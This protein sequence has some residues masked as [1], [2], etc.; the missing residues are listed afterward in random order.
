[1]GASAALALTGRRAPL[2]A[3]RGSVEQARDGGP[4]LLTWHPSLI[5]RLP[6]AEARAARS[7]F[8]A[9]LA[10]AAAMLGPQARS[11]SL[12]SRDQ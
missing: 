5:L 7:D 8:A 10:R 1:M 4:V 2:T 11:R 12:A 9:D 6:A 3:R